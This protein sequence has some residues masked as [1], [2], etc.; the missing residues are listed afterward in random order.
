MGGW[1]NLPRKIDMG[2]F[3]RIKEAAKKI[4]STAI[5]GM[6]GYYLGCKTAT[7]LFHMIPGAGTIAAMGMSA[8]QNIIFT[9]RFAITLT[10]IFSKGNVNRDSLVDAIKCMFAGTGIGLMSVRDIA[11]LYFN[12]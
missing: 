7:R 2:E 9:Y 12:Y 10:R 6:G 3:V 8:L 1:F 11:S 5:L 4:C